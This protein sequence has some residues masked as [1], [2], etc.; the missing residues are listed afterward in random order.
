MFRLVLSDAQ[1]HLSIFIYMHTYIW[2]SRASLIHI[3]DMETY[4]CTHL[5]MC[6]HILCMSPYHI[7]DMETYIGSV[8]T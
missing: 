2:G 6:I 5:I 3:Y 1:H 7:Y 8:Y 4:I